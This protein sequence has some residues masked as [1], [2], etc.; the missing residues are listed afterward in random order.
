[1]TVLSSDEE[2]V[3]ENT[4]IAK[5]SKEKVNKVKKTQVYDKEALGKY[6]KHFNPLI[7]GF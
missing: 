2:D 3:V 5:K 7:H 4:Q 6:Y 1:M